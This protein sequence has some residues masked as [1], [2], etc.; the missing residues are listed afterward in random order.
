MNSNSTHV[1]LRLTALI[2]QVLEPASQIPEPFPVDRQLNELG[3]TSL[4]MLNLML[5]VEAEFHVAISQA[6][7][8]PENFQSLSS[9]QSMVER[10]KTS[11]R[12]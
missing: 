5:A 8:T 2:N 12:V 3:V 7:I 9:I 1:R 6:D 4:N 10:I 11:S